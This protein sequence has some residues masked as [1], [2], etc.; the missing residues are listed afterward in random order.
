[1]TLHCVLRV[2]IIAAACQ[3]LGNTRLKHMSC[4]LRCS[5]SVYV[6]A[7]ECMLGRRIPAVIRKPCNKQERAF[8]A[9][10]VVR[11]AR[12]IMAASDRL[13]R[14]GGTHTAYDSLLTRHY[15]HQLRSHCSSEHM[16]FISACSTMN[17][18]ADILT[19]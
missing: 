19:H 9:Q 2:S 15:S 5:T 13:N 6:A 7:L 12:L 17:M 4:N 18:L 1:M 8:N 3:L 11:A 16:T 10:I 14:C